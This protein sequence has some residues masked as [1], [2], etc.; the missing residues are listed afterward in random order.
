MLSRPVVLV[1][2]VTEK[3]N[4]VIPQQRPDTETIQKSTAKLD[5]LCSTRDRN[6]APNIKY[7]MPVTTAHEYGFWNTHAPKCK[8]TMFD[9]KR[10][11]GDVSKYADSYVN[12]TGRSPF[13]RATDL[14]TQ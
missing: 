9:H 6:T 14:P 5:E 4:Y 10:H 3:P 13:S 2:V 8:D 1:Q 7:R 12:M 11:A